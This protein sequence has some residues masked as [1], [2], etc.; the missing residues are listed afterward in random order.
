MMIWLQ[1]IKGESLSIYPASL[2][3][4]AGD[5]PGLPK[6]GRFEIKGRGEIAVKTTSHD[7]FGISVMDCFM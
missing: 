4:M 6:R 5:P 3:S 1:P 2:V 7:I